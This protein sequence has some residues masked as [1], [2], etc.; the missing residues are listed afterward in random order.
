M[1]QVSGK[2]RT[3]AGK[4]G[5]PGNWSVVG[6]E[7][8]VAWLQCSLANNRVSHAYCITGPPHVGKTTLAKAFATALL[9]Q[10]E[11]GQRPC[12]HCLACRKLA[13]DNHPDLRLVEAAGTTIR[14]DQIRELRQ[15][16]VLSPVEGRYKVF[17]L[18]EMERATAAAAN[19]LLKTLE[20]PPPHV[21]LLLTAT[22]RDALLPTITSRCQMVNLRALPVTQVESALRD[23]WNATPERA[24]LL[25]RLSAGRL[26]QAVCILQ[27][28]HR[29]ERRTAWLDDLV[30]LCRS[31]RAARLLYAEE[32]ARQRE[33][34]P[35]VLMLW[36]SWWRDLLLLQVGHSGEVTNIDRNDE[37]EKMAQQLTPDQ[38]RVAVQVVTATARYL[39]ANV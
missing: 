33:V 11:P 27:D 18:P 7:W 25:A 4:F 28:E 24:A 13:T 19:A 35:E 30:R 8:A 39:E 9:C 16:A 22:R 32:L 36:S 23:H 10:A 5:Q 14:I 29:L 37:L 17:I 6:H 21:V 26:G 2:A 31:G 20:E 1:Q 34:I 12:G 38:V 3:R 15:E